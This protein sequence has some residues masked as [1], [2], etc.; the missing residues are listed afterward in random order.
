MINDFSTFEDCLKMLMEKAVCETPQE[1]KSLHFPFATTASNDTS[2]NDSNYQS[3]NL[4]STD[5]N[6]EIPIEHPEG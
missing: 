2:A 5:A 6:T 1:E 4:T 3:S